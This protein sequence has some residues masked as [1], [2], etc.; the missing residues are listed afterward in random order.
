MSNGSNGFA[1]PYIAHRETVFSRNCVL[2][3]AFLVSLRRCARNASSVIHVAGI[4][5]PG[6]SAARTK[7][8]P[9]VTVGTTTPAIATAVCRTLTRQIPNTRSLYS[10]SFA[11]SRNC[12][13]IRMPACTI[14]ARPGSSP[15]RDSNAS[16]VF[17]E[18]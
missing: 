13:N 18:C 2:K 9:A 1:V 5:C 15:R 17:C 16:I 12:V 6:G 4:Q 11:S 10:V 7:G 8:S 3:T 14:D